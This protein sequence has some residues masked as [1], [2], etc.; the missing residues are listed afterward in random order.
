MGK[1]TSKVIEV[2]YIRGN[3][4]RYIVTNT[5]KIILVTYDLRFAERIAAAI[6]KQ[7]NPRNFAVK[8]K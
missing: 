8:I 4:K 6:L 7:E 1:S 5:E 3:Q 2:L